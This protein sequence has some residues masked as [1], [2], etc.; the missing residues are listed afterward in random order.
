MFDLSVQIGFRINLQCPD[1][2]HYP[3]DGDS[4]QGLN[5]RSVWPARTRRSDGDLWAHPVSAFV[6]FAR[7]VM[8]TPPQAGFS[9]MD[10]AVAGD[11][12]PKGFRPSRLSGKFTV[13]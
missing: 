7:S 10:M 1:G 11:S 5:T 3:T 12:A 9:A 8:S 13:Q 2:F 4:P 6:A